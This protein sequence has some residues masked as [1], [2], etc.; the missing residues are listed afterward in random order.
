MFTSIVDTKSTYRYYQRYSGLVL[1]A[2]AIRVLS[3]AVEKVK[4]DRVEGT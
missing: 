2:F 1:I 3:S 4:Q